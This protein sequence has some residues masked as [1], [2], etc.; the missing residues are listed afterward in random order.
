MFPA[1]SLEIISRKRIVADRLGLEQER[2]VPT[3]ERPV[4]GKPDDKSM[5]VAIEPDRLS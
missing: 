1:G 4:P 5:K 2:R 3:L